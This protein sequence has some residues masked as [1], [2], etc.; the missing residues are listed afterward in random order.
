MKGGCQLGT[1]VV[2]Y[3][4]KSDLPLAFSKHFLNTFSNSV[5]MCTMQCIYAETSLSFNGTCTT[6]TFHSKITQR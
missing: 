5:T 4:S 1:K 3:D 6:L 2:N